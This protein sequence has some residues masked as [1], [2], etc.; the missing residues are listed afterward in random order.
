MSFI[1]MNE[2]VLRKMARERKLLSRRSRIHYV[3]S[4]SELT[5]CTV[6][7]G[8]A[9]LNIQSYKATQ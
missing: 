6:D 1:C 4:I 7:L 8:V 5:V 3:M 9:Y 2:M